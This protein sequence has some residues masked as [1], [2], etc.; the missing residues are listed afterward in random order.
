MARGSRVTSMAIVAINSGCLEAKV[1]D[2]ASVNIGPEYIGHNSH[3]GAVV[4]SPDHEKGSIVE[5]VAIAEKEN[6]ET[7]VVV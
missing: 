1:E 6:A 3:V 7:A 4:I 5:N 2:K